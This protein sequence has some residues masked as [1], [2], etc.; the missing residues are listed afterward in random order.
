[1][2]AKRSRTRAGAAA[3]FMAT[4]GAIG[5]SAALASAAFFIGARTNL[6]LFPWGILKAL[7]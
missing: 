7:R 1:M 4:V 2:S 6:L 5:L 3:L